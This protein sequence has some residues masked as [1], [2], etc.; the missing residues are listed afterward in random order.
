MEELV[1]QQ[2]QAF[3][4]CATMDDRDLFEYHLRHYRIMAL[5]REMDRIARAM[6]RAHGW[7]ASCLSAR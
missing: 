2:I 3:K 6:Q 1:S 5:Y 7:L 4:N